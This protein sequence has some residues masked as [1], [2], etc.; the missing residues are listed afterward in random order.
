MEIF[1]FSQKLKFNNTAIALGDFDGIHIAHQK[2]ICDCIC[3]AKKN[4]LKSGVMLFKNSFKNMPIISSLEERI[5]LIEKLGADFVFLCEFSEDFKKKTP[6]EFVKFLKENLFV[7]V[8][9]VGYNYRFGYQAKGDVTMLKM[10]AQKEDIKAII[11]KEQTLDGVS[12]SSTIVREMILKNKL[13]EAKKF[14]G[15]KYFV[16]GIVKKGLQNG[17]KLGFKTANLQPDLQRVLPPDGVYAGKVFWDKKEYNAVI[18]IGKNPTFD[19]EKRTIES[20]LTDFDGDLYGEKITVEFHFFLRE[21][22]KFKNLR[23]LKNQ[24]KKDKERAER[25]LEGSK[26]YIIAGLGN[27]GK[28]YDMTRHNIGFEVIDYLSDKYNVKVNKLKFKSL[29]AETKVSGKKVYLLKPQ[30]FMN[31][32]GE[33]IREFSSFFKIPSSNI[34]IINDDISLEAGKIRLRRKGSAGGHN[35]LKSIIYQLKTD[36]FPRIKMGVGAPKH[37]DHDLADFVLGKFSKEEIPILENA[38]IKAAKA[39]EEIVSIGIDSA[40]NKYSS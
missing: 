24:I 17:K 26:T 14:L 22:K 32:S 19:A 31:L 20:H 6:E 33:A 4:N 7:K 40:M 8:L 11:C 28:E 2:V 13:D 29:Y 5:E 15:R 38:I 18:N 21:E 12:V 27:P 36:E 25:E 23:E 39:A 9:F 1:D 16:S 10:L 3:Y 37:E 34:I 30:T 35:G